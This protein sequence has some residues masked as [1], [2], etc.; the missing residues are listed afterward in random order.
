MPNDMKKSDQNVTN[1]KVPR[2]RIREIKNE[3][4]RLRLELAQIFNAAPSHS[5][6]ELDFKPNKLGSS[7]EVGKSLV[8]CATTKP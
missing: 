5:A 2:R 6:A 3:L 1:A 4:A 7:T 8:P